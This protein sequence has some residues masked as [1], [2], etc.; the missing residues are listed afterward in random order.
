MLFMQARI[1]EHNFAW[2]K[3][4]LTV[5]LLLTLAHVLPASGQA[6][7]EAG[8][9]K[10]DSVKITGSARFRSEQIATSTGLSPGTVVSKGDLQLGADRLA[11]LGTFAT[12]EYRFSTTDA[13]VHV[14][15]Q[16]TDAPGIPVWFDNFP[17]FT[18][19]QLIAALKASV[20][21]FDG[22]A[23]ERGTLLDDIA[24]A[25]QTILATH[26]MHPSVSHALITVPTSGQRVQQFRAE[27][28]VL[29]IASV[30]FSDALA[31]NDRGIQTR[32][33]DI[34]GHPFSRAAVE[35]FES[36][37]VR[38]LYLSHGYL[39][40]RFGA[41]TAR[42]V[43]AGNDARVA[44][45]VPID[46]GPAFGWNGVAWSGNAVIPTTQLDQLATLKPGEPADG[47]K[48]E[49]IWQSVRDAYAAR[50]YLEMNLNAVPQFDTFSSRVTYN[51]AIT[52]GPQY[53]MGKL[54]LTG[55]SIEGERRIRAAWK[56][57]PGEVF[58]KSAY[59]EFFASGVKEAFAGL[60]FHYEKI[61][62]FFQEDPKT[63]TVDVL[64]DFQ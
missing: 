38:P 23:P 26:G 2:V 10:L 64:V 56:I 51:V 52:E 48:I 47:T 41:P 55:L 31:Q 16:V 35:L 8:S 27:G 46:P 49:G 24:D 25:L 60:P 1:S 54:V 34:I 9:G 62:R 28:S 50:G 20:A 14:E 17:G 4:A 57:A 42:F 12:V 22:T 13:G 58:N 36:E 40:V 15:Y 32:V 18:D 7:A 6:P 37:Q 11:R 43:G 21:L 19:A 39:R 59:D 3:A 30:E 5:I 29:N 44:L 33:G 63:G 45:A 53:R 61:G